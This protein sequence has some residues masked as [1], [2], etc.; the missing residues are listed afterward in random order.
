MQSNGTAF[1]LLLKNSDMQVTPIT[2]NSETLETHR[3]GWVVMDS[4]RILANAFVQIRN[5]VITRVGNWDGNPGG[6]VID[7]G[8]GALFPS[9]VNVHTHLELSALK[10]MLPFGKGFEHWVK[11]LIYLR[12]K[13]DDSVLHDG[14]VQ[15]LLELV[16]SGCF[17]AGEIASLGMFD[18]DFK[19]SEVDGVYFNEFLGGLQGKPIE[20][21]SKE[22]IIVS[23]AGHAP[24]T[25]S[26][27]LLV[28]LK[29][30]C[31]KNKTPFSIHLSE[32]DEEVEFIKTGKGRWANFLK[33]RGID[34]TSWPV[35]E[36]GSVDYLESLGLLD[37]TTIAVHLIRAEKEDYQ[38]L[39][40][41]NVNVCL[42]LRSNQNLHK[43]LPDVMKMYD[44]NLHLCLGTDSLA[45][46]QSLSILDE[47]QFLREKFP[48]IPPYDIFKMGTA[49]GAEALGVADKFGSIEKGKA[50]KIVYAPLNVSKGSDL[51]SAL[52]R[53]DS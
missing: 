30:L 38:T 47:M 8:E 16:N 11:E 34:Y 24:H 10:G 4:E 49:N 12:E 52:M 5:G 31:H 27:E 22:G 44:G 36:K 37:D 45:S 6:E 40:R 2:N 25:T 41:N 3:A 21:P 46:T 19:D 7:H 20:G 28:M 43:R 35:T 9:L 14:M 29:T 51:F 18:K 1:T 15:G 33:Q 42:C 26:P 50:G 48:Q 32:S 17:V 23:F 39:K 13:T 53:S